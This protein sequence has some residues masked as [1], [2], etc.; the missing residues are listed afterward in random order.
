MKLTEQ[1]LFHAL[2]HDVHAGQ[3]CVPRP[4]RP[5]QLGRIRFAGFGR[6]EFVELNIWFIA[7]EPVLVE[8]RRGE[9]VRGLVL[10]PLFSYNEP[11]ARE[12]LTMSA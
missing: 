7:K 5:S 3:A 11:N 12:I 4:Q 9:R 2:E 10:V 8:S 6:M 1:A